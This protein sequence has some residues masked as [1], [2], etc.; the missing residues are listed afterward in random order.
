MQEHVHVLPVGCCFL[1]RQLP[2]DPEGLT[3]RHEFTGSLI[4]E[5]E[6]G[7]QYCRTVPFWKRL[8]LGHKMHPCSSRSS[9]FFDAFWLSAFPTG[10]G[11][12]VL[13]A[14]VICPSHFFTAGRARARARMH[15]RAMHAMRRR[16]VRAPERA[17]VG[18][19]GHRRGLPNVAALH[20]LRRY[21]L[22]TCV[23]AG[24]CCSCWQW[25]RRESVDFLWPP[26]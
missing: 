22:W 25:R 5:L 15:E 16:R 13:L 23:P 19:E 2:V 9:Q 26:A 24:Y 10:S 21:R 7:L 8:D 12:L 20:S 4:V 11:C 18:A 17:Q 1:V 3:T 14:T 6:C